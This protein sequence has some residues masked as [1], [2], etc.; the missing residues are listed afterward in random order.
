MKYKEYINR[1]VYHGQRLNFIKKYYYKYICPQTN[2]VYLIRTFLYYKGSGNKILSYL[3]KLYKYR[4]IKKYNIF[5]GDNTKI[6]IGLD[7]PHPSSIVI[8][9]KVVI[10]ENCTIYHE[11]TFGGARRGDYSKGNYPKVGDNCVFFAGSK[12]IGNINIEDNVIVGANCLINRNCLNGL[13]YVG[14]PGKPI[15]KV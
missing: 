5:I 7:L 2:A 6:A 3:S 1:E 11:V 8:G 4:L 13:T 14:I 12:I 9:D 15:N 10:G